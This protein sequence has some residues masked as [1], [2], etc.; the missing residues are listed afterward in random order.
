MP[1][2]AKNVKNTKCAL[3]IVPKSKIRTKKYQ[4]YQKDLKYQIEIF[5]TSS[6]KFAKCAK[7]AKNA[8]ID[9]GQIKLLAL[10]MANF[11]F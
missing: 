5:G 4:K 8:K 10:K 1:K 2:S 6:A 9:K 3:S 7:N 11:R